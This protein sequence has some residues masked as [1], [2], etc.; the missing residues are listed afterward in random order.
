MQVVESLGTDL[1]LVERLELPG[2]GYLCIAIG[3]VPAPDPSRVWV[4]AI[5]ILL[6]CGPK[7]EDAVILVI[8]AE[9]V[10]LQR[11]PV[12][13]VGRT[14]HNAIPA[15]GGMR[16]VGSNGGCRRAPL[17]PL[18]RAVGGSTLLLV[19]KFLAIRGDE[20]AAKAGGRPEKA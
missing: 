2:I 6:S 7:A 20:D 10:E 12:G 8:R 13:S 11:V 19:E 18:A 3:S 4:G 9:A 14:F 17:N 1:L 5:R 15:V 16:W